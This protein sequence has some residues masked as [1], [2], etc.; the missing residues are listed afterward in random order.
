MGTSVTLV[1][2]LSM[3]LTLVG[4]FGVKD[5]KAPFYPTAF[6]LT[7]KHG[8][9]TFGVITSIAVLWQKYMGTI[10]ISLIPALLIIGVI[11]GAVSGEINY[12]TLK[13]VQ[14]G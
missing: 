1:I 12:L 4:Y 8:F 6:W 11:A 7:I 3:I 10:E 14:K 2:T 9:F 5:K 13:N